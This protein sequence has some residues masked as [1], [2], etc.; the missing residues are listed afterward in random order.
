MKIGLFVN[1]VEQIGGAEI[2]TRRLAECLVRRGHHVILIGSQ[3]ASIWQQH[4]SFYDYTN[5]IHLVRL[6]V[7]QRSRRTFTWTLTAHAL[8][9]FPIFLRQT[10]ILHLR[11]LTPE[12]VTLAQIARR[13]GIKT[14]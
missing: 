1:N 13:L 2:A 11:S 9:A 12:T 8:W 14:I 5:E 6:P 4:R 10:Q 3:A 7:W